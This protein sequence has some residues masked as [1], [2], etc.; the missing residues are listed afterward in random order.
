LIGRARAAEV[1]VL[2]SIGGGSASGDEAMKARYFRLLGDEHR[3]GF[4]LKIA[5]YVQDHGFDGV[6]VD[7]EG[8]SINGD[9]G[10]FIADLA[11]ALQPQG[12][13]LTAALSKGY[14]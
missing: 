7:I 13:L 9:Y 14:G 10:K 4:V 8:P 3:A 2:V 1:K 6:D 12:K 5:R 11:A